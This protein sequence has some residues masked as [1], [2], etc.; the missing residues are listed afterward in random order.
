MTSPLSF[1]TLARSLDSTGLVGSRVTVQSGMIFATS[2]QWSISFGPNERVHSF[3]PVVFGAI[4]SFGRVLGDKS[5]LYKYLNPHMIV[6][7][8]TDLERGTGSV[9]V[10][11]SLT[12][13]SLY[14]ASVDQVDTTR[15]II[16]TISENWLVFSWLEV[17][18][19]WRITSVELY[20][21]TALGKTGQT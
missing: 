8:S 9:S 13:K 15:G 1:I 14:T 18:G 6:V 4:S 5:T 20:E 2:A 7:T 10:V 21:D 12:G 11:D 3:E 19:G 16:A 17:G